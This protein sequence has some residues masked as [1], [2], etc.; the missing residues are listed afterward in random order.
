MRMPQRCNVTAVHRP[1]RHPFLV[2][3]SK[4]FTIWNITQIKYK[5]NYVDKQLKRERIHNKPHLLL[6]LYSF[7]SRQLQISA[8]RHVE[9]PIFPNCRTT[10]CGDIYQIAPPDPTSP[11]GRA[12]Q[13]PTWTAVDG[14]QR[15]PVISQILSAPFPSTPG[16]STASK[17]F[18]ICASARI[19]LRRPHAPFPTF[20]SA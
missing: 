13:N 6:K 3:R 15:L 7:V 19:D 20:H 4:T 16:H 10:N 18:C 14:G 12:S 17:S 2:Y 9:Y 11:S 5:N 1:Q 8:T